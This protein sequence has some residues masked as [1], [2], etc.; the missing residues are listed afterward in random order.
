MNKIV[1]RQLYNINVG[2]TANKNPL[3]EYKWNI[4][5]NVAAAPYE[6]DEH[7][8]YVYKS[9]AAK[10]AKLGCELI[11]KKPFESENELTAVVATLTMLEINGI[12]LAN[13]RND[14]DSLK[15]YL[16]DNNV[17]EA[18]KWINRHIVVTA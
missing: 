17:D 14:I 16:S 10:A 18:E 3:S 5:K 8:Y 7:F 9:I 15:Q 2:I 6:Q 11:R 13:Y 12:K 4:L 1:T